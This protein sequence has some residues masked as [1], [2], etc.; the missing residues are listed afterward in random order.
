MPKKKRKRIEKPKKD[1][2]PPAARIK[3][4]TS[5]AILGKRNFSLFLTLGVALLTPVFVFLYLAA[6]TSDRISYEHKITSWVKGKAF[7]NDTSKGVL[8]AV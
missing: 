7:Y 2:P 3:E 5:A 8:F 1:L 4:N 6:S